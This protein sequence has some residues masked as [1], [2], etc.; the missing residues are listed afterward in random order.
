MHEQY[1]GWLKDLEKQKESYTP[2]QLITLRGGVAMSKGFVQWADE[3]LKT[4][5]QMKRAK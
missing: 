5:S 2:F 4:L 3:S 1:A